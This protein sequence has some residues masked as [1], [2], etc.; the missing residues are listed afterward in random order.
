MRDWRAVIKLDD[1]WEG[2][3][4]RCTVDGVDLLLINI[5]GHVH[6]F[7]DRCPHA[8]TPLNQGKLESGILTCAAHLWQFDIVNG[9]IGVNPQD[10]RLTSYP[11]RIEDGE[12]LVQLGQSALGQYSARVS[13]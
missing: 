12:V 11:V 5:D 2:D 1:L 8:G 10:C 6:A 4:V 7:E 9:G 3:L 13:T